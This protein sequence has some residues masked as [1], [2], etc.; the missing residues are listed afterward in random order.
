MEFAADSVRR[1]I[2]VGD[3]PAGERILLDDLAEDLGISPIPVREALRVVATEGLVVPVARRGYTVA[4][5]RVEDLEETYRLRLLLEPLAVQLAVPQLTPAEVD[6]LA[7]ELDLLAEAFSAGDWPNHRLHHRNFH[8]GIY[9][10][11][12]SPWLLRFTE[13]LWANSERYQYVTTRIKGELRQRATEHKRI[14]KAVRAG[15]GDGAA[16]LMHDHLTQAEK[17]L[18]AYLAAREA[19]QADEERESATASS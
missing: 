17:P 5:L 4:P 15:D 12:N 3:L 16:T 10:K 6:G 8:F 18:H 7:E 19:Q 13:M 2:L 14:L 11:C 9:D 1:S